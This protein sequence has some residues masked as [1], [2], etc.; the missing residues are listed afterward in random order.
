MRLKFG[1]Y[2]VDKDVY[3]NQDPTYPECTDPVVDREIEE[4]IIPPQHTE[5]AQYYD[6][7]L[8]RLKSPIKYSGNSYIFKDN[9]QTTHAL[10]ISLTHSIHMS[11]SLLH[12]PA[13][14]QPRKPITRAWTNVPISH[15]LRFVLF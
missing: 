13:N 12:P 3:C 11:V 5:Q 4:V 9:E 6:I 7:A 15:Y 10:F 8:V 14:G 1:L 2:D